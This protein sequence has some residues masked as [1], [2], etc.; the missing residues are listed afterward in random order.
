MFFSS[1]YGSLSRTERMLHHKSALNKFKE[2]EIAS[3]ISSDHKVMKLEI[4]YKWKIHKY[5]EI[6]NHATEQPMG[7]R[8]LNK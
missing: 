8:K 5:V 4:N 6:K 7:Q 2:T 1:A 3:D